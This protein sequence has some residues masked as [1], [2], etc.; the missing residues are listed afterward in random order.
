MSEWKDEDISR[1]LREM[2]R[3]RASSGF[4]ERVMAGLDRPKPRAIVTR[5]PGLA[6]AGLSAALL[7]LAV[8][9]GGWLSRPEP[10]LEP[11]PMP[12]IST[13]DAPPVAKRPDVDPASATRAAGQRE[14]ERQRL[15][16]L[17]AEYRDLE[18]ELRELRI[19]VTEKRPMIE[20][21]GTSE[22]DFVLDVGELARRDSPETS[23]VI[24][25]ERTRSR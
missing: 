22:M 20:L 17:R 6:L 5:Q 19:L 3:G 23:P 7:A 13:A 9:L 10:E 24:H 8:G 1:I 15:E 18:N 21:G 14:S 12:P 4:T 25:T 11:E 16:R 2:P